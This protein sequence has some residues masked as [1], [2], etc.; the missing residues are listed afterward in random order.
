MNTRAAQTE[1]KRTRAIWASVFLP[2]SGL[3]AL[4]ERRLGLWLL[5]SSAMFLVF[6]AYRW[7]CV[8]AAFASGKL[9]RVVAAI[10]LLL[11][12]LGLWAFSLVKTLRSWC[13][14]N[15]IES[16]ESFTPQVARRYQSWLAQGKE[17]LRRFFEQE[18]QKGEVPNYVEEK[19]SFVRGNIKLIGR[20]DRADVT[21]EGGVIIDYKTS[22]VRD[23][24]RADNEARNSIQLP[25]YAMAYRERFGQLPVSVELRFLETGLVG[26]LKNLE[27]AI[28]KTTAKIE[29]VADQVKQRDFAPFPQYMAC[30]FCPYRG[31]CPYEGK[32]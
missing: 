17:V 15:K 18:Q 16:I 31:I 13:H 4:G 30:E 21:Q 29:R 24:A 5:G 6:A 25:I 9:D 27:R 32:R 23:Q 28:E 26:R 3:M 10:F 7:D 14:Q 11:V 1:K 22:E 2:G 19:F 20:W 12:L 8:L